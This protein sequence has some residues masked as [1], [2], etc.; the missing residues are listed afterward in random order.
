MKLVEVVTPAASDDA[1]TARTSAAVLP[2][3][4][5]VY[6]FRDMRGRALYIGRAADLRSRVRSYWGPLGDRRHLAR[7]VPKVARIEAVVCQSRHE[8]AWLE[9]SML[10]HRLLP[11]NRTAGGAEVAVWLR[12]TDRGVN[13]EHEVVGSGV[14]FGPY[15]GGG[16]A[17]SAAAALNDVY[18]FRYATT[19]SGAERDMARIRG[20]LPTDGVRMRATVEAVLSGD[21]EAV[22]A[23]QAELLRR[24]QGSVDAMD[25]ERAAT[26]QRQLD[27]LAWIVQP[28]R[29]LERGPDLDLHGWADGLLLTFEL[30]DGAIR[31]WRTRPCTHRDAESRLASTPDRWRAFATEN[32]ALAAALR[33]RAPTERSP[34]ATAPSGS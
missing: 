7:M 15:L 22:E 32:A 23:M 9:R 25:F 4:P 20:V 18:P 3:R 30:R 6:R 28:S 10:E 5:G 21:T 14:R 24:R 26:I 33:E 13:V 34:G 29:V 12:L 8:A 16:Q 27:G 17:R 11:W 31:D 1:G 2:T 19:R